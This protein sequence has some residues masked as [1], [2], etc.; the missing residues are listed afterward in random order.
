MYNVAS[1]Y[2]RIATDYNQYASHDFENYRL[3][4][5]QA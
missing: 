1:V 2:S 5:M 3:L 4:F